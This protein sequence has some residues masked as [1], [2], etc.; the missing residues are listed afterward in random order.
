M[1]TITVYQGQN[2]TLEVAFRTTAG[3]NVPVYKTAGGAEGVNVVIKRGGVS[4]LTS[5]GSGSDGVYSFQNTFYHGQWEEGTYNVTFSGFNGS[6]TAVSM[7]AEL[8]ILKSY[9]FTPSGNQYFIADIIPFL[10]EAIGNGPHS[11]MGEMAFGASNG[12]N[13]RFSVMGNNLV[14]GSE[15]VTKMAASGT[16]TGFTAGAQ[17]NGYTADYD[18]GVFDLTAAPAAGDSI[19]VSYFHK[20]Y[21]RGQLTQAA[22]RACTALSNRGL[23]AVSN[24]N[25]QPTIDTNPATILGM[26]MLSAQIAVL[27]MQVQVDARRSFDFTDAGLSMKRSSIPRNEAQVLKDFKQ[28]LEDQ[29]CAAAM[30][31]VATA[32]PA[33]ADRPEPQ[34]MIST[35]FELNP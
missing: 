6:G 15:T 20:T 8:V 25:G 28:Q 10:E 26:L 29:V 12:T 1:A 22:M 21:S 31:T 14:P 18:N 32:P 19:I 5:T 30:D 33:D 3:V 35:I 13:R 27:E 23:L 4:M 34:V 7:S 9:V 2:A 16:Q 11:A 17:S 24:V